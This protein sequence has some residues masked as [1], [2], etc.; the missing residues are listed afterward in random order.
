M[1]VNDWKISQLRTAPVFDDAKLPERVELYNLD[2]DVYML[3]DAA[4][5]VLI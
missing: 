3:R 1:D 4:Q 2:C 5:P